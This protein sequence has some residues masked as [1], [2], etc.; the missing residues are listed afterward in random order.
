LYA[1]RPGACVR[2][3]SLLVLSDAAPRLYLVQRRVRLG[4]RRHRGSADDELP[5]P[6]LEAGMARGEPRK[7]LRQ[8]GPGLELLPRGSAL[9][10]AADGEQLLLVRI[11]ER[12][13]AAPAH[14]KSL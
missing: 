3:P 9:R 8:V 14:A 10:T 13:L 2:T 11:P 4:Q 7:Q 12:P 5:V 1:V 6:V